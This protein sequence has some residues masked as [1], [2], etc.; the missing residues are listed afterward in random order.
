MAPALDLPVLDLAAV[1]ARLGRRLPAAGLICLLSACGGGGGGE[2]A[3][4][5]ASA[6]AAAPSPGAAA[7]GDATT[8]RRLGIAE[9]LYAGTPRVPDGFALD[10]APAGITGPVATLHLKNTDVGLAGAR[11]E[12]C[13]SDPAEAL[14]WSEQRASWQGSYADLVETNASATLF[15]FVRVP[16]SDTT[17]RLRHRVLRCS[18]LDRNA[19][20][21]DL[22]DGAAGVLKPAP[23]G[24][25]ALRAA[26]E[27]L[28]QFT[29][30]N[31]AD[32]VVLSSSAGPASAGQLG[33]QLEMARLVRGAVGAQCDRIDRLAWTHVVDVASGTLTRRLQTLESFGAR[34][35][36]AGVSLCSG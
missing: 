14:A 21:L 26:A 3:T 13:T 36:A 12:L 8:T 33:W 23:V 19:T 27:Y 24:A 34:R 30:F 10:P 35:D 4:S 1:A 11:H 6:T 18:W 31:N 9:K 15:E 25:D 5:S 16:R 17:A 20:D 2:A 32:H 28:W 22:D 29:A 7:V